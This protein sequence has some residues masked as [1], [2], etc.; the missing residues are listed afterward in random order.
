MRTTAV[1]LVV[2]G[3]ALAGCSE[4]ESEEPKGYE[5]ASVEQVG[6]G[7]K[8]VTFTSE[9]AR[10]V[11]LETAPV[12]RSGRYSVVPYS[13]LIYAPDGTTLV[14]ASPAPRR[15]V[16][17]TVQVARISGGTVLL[18]TGPPAG[19]AVVSVGA[20]QVHGA[21]LEIAGGH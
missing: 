8:R 17:T 6:A 11:G 13:A 12:R 9:G 16:P 2:A 4:L 18:T 19:T 5:P 3:M 15:Y 1:V 10:R 21:E 14:Y 7:G 20:T